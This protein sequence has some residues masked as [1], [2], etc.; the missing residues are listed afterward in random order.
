MIMIF[1]MSVYSIVFSE[2]VKN[3][4]EYKYKI[5]NTKLDLKTSN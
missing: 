3:I 5:E 4:E 2:K 1:E